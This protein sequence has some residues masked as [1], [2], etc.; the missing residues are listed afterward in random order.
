VNGLNQ[1]C[2]FAKV[3][4]EASDIGDVP[5]LLEEPAVAAKSSRVWP[6]AAG[7]LAAG[8]ILGIVGWLRLGTAKEPPAVALSIVPP[9]GVTLGL[10]SI[11]A[12]VSPDGTSIVYAADDFRMYLRRLDSLESRVAPGGSVASPAFWSPDSTT[13]VRHSGTKQGFI[14]VR[15]PDGA[16]EFFGKSSAVYRGG[17][18]SE[19]G[20]ILITGV[21]S[22]L[23]VIPASGGD[24]RA[25][26][27]PAPLKDGRCYF[28][29]FLP[30]SDDFL[31][32][33]APFSKSDEAAVYLATLRDGKVVEPV[34][35][36]KNQTGAR[37]TPAGGGR[38]LFVR[39]DNLYS[40]KLNRQARKLEGEP[41]LLRR[42][43]HLRRQ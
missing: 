43:S 23:E 4:P 6:L 14:K 22:C 15:I 2:L 40:Q 18:W 30:G 33:F 25:V 21:P 13:V 10:L 16:P 36:L 42:A 35:L 29:N 27:M 9:P 11:P 31:F 7:A 32:L 20:T 17:T 38:I 41:E 12:E 3:L 5:L 34:A 28:P 24:G 19:A 37:Y 1:G 8:A 26:E 39:S